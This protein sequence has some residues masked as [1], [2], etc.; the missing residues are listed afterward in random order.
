MSKSDNSLYNTNGSD[1]PIVIILYVDDLV[2]GCK[3]LADVN[4]LKLLQ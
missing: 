4:K 1:N 3:N 2:I